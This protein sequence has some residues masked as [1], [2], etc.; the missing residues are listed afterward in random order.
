MNRQFVNPLLLMLGL[1]CLLTFGAARAEETMNLDLKSLKALPEV[2]AVMDPAVR[3]FW[4]DSPAPELA[5]YSPSDVFN[6]I[7]ISVIPFNTSQKHCEEAF[8][9]SIELMIAE[10]RNAGYDVIHDI[11]PALREGPSKDLNRVFCSLSPSTARVVLSARFGM[12]PTAQARANSIDLE[13]E[14]LAAS[15]ARPAAKGALYVPLQALLASP[16]FKT[17]LGAD[18]GFYL[19]SQVPPRYSQRFGPKTYTESVEA[20]GASPDE[21]CRRAVLA[22]LRSLITDAR[23]HNYNAVIRVRSFLN[24]QLTPSPNDAECEAGNR[25]AKASF[26]AILVVRQ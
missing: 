7:G 8:R 18:M 6:G 17:I 13:A 25:S 5:E 9:K 14:R 15:T 12:T 10:A 23:G 11:R 3:L 24:D 26:R 2:Q 16:E 19:G 4:Y 22:A 1:T 21:T 20:N